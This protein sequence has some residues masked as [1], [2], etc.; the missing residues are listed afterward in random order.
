MCSLAR[1]KIAAL[2]CLGLLAN[3]SCTNCLL[4]KGGYAWKQGQPKLDLG[5]VEQRVCFLT[6]VSGQFEGGGEQIRVWEDG[7]HWWLSGDSKQS[8]ISAV[9]HCMRKDCFK[10][11]GSA[12]DVSPQFEQSAL[13]LPGGGVFGSAGECTEKAVD[14]YAGDA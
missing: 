5:P 12:R 14:A 13:A 1:M 2:A 6:K 3:A 4:T 11:Q 9:A 8:G 7:V 10:A